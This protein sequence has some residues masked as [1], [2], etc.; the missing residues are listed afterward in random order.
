MWLAVR[1]G[2][3]ELKRTFVV[4]VRH[5]MLRPLT[6]RMPARPEARHRRRVLKSYL[7]LLPAML[8][9]RWMMNRRISR[10]SLMKWE[11]SK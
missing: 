11:V 6:L 4:N 8:R 10:G 2:L 3:G 5:L 1:S 7:T 9:D